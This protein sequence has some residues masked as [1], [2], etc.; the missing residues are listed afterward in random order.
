MDMSRGDR[1]GIRTFLSSCATAM[2]RTDGEPCQAFAPGDG[3][4]REI[5]EMG[6]EQSTGGSQARGLEDSISSLQQ[7]EAGTPR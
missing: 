4:R 7:S 2:L 1:A 5:H 3:S 6:L